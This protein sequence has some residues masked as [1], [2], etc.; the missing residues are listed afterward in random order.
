MIVAPLAVVHILFVI[1]LLV[2]VTV[3][4]FFV[5]SLVS[6]TFQSQTSAFTRAR[7]VFSVATG[8]SVG[9]AVHA[10]VFH[11]YVF[12]SIV[13]IFALVTALFAIVSAVAPVTSP[14]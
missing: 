5:A 13:A 9:T 10:V 11:L 2:R 8:T 14:V 4:L 3:A 12:V 6:S 1:L 7:S